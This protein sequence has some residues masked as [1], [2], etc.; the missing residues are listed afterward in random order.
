V[1]P[2][3]AVSINADCGLTIFNAWIAIFE[4]IKTESEIA[5]K[6]EKHYQIIPNS[7]LRSE[8]LKNYNQSFLMTKTI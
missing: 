4:F 6:E 7:D 3:I 5:I 8:D 1:P 2:A